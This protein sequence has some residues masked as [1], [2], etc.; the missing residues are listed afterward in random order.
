MQTHETGFRLPGKG[1]GFFCVLFS[2]AENSW[3]GRKQ[4][5]TKRKVEYGL[6]K[7]V[8]LQA[9]LILYGFVYNSLNNIPRNEMRCLEKE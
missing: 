4:Y 5:K 1:G 8:N 9:I 3:R 7:M 6:L 2:K